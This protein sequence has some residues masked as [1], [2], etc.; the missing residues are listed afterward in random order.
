MAYKVDVLTLKSS[1]IKVIGKLVI[2]DSAD[3]FLSKFQIWRYSIS[4]ASLFVR[5][6]QTY[7]ISSRERA[8]K[9]PYLHS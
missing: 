2:R 9:W 1:N 5:L 4:Y 6:L 3:T 8:G 7:H